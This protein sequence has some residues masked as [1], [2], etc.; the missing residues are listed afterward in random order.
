MTNPFRFSPI[1]YDM[2]CGHL[3]NYFNLQAN[4]YMADSMARANL[5]NVPTLNFGTFTP[6]GGVSIPGEMIFNYTLNQ[7]HYQSLQMGGAGIFNSDGSLN[8]TGNIFGG[9]GFGS[10]IG[11]NYNPFGGIGFTPWQTPSV[12][13]GNGNGSGNGKIDEKLQN[14]YNKLKNLLETYVTKNKNIDEDL[15][16][17]IKEAFKAKGTLEEKY[18]ALKEVFDDIDKNELRKVILTLKDLDN[19]YYED[20][21]VD[22]GYDFDAGTSY[23]HD[24]SELI[25]LIGDARQEIDQLVKDNKKFNTISEKEKIAG[26]A[27]YAKS[28]K[29]EILNIISLWNEKNPKLNIVDAIYKITYLTN[30]ENN[31]QKTTAELI[32]GFNSAL[33]YKAEK[34]KLGLSGEEKEEIDSLIDA[35]STAQTD[36]INNPTNTAKWNTMKTAFNNLYSK[37]RIVEAEKINK[38][39]KNQYGFLNEI[40]EGTIADDIIVAETIADLNDEGIT[41]ETS[42]NSGNGDGAGQGTGAGQGA[43]AGQNT[44]EGTATLATSSTTS[45]ESEAYQA[46]RT[47]GTN[48]CGGRS[49]IKNRAIN[50][51]LVGNNDDKSGIAFSAENVVEFLDGMYSAKNNKKGY[52]EKMDK[53]SGKG[54][55]D[56]AQRKNIISATLEAAKDCGLSQDPSYLTL[57]AVYDEMIKEGSTVKFND[58]NKTEDNYWKIKDKA[59]SFGI[60]VGGG[61]VAG[62][63]AGVATAAGLGMAA[64][65][66]GVVGFLASN[67]V[68]W[69]VAA[70]LAVVAGATAISLAIGKRTNSE[71]IDDCMRDLYEKIKNNEQNKRSSGVAQTEL[72]N[73]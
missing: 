30:A 7:A 57:K 23:E 44:G 45:T 47:V 73:G 18:S 29:D 26:F 69:A 61:V 60:G 43:G 70:C 40:E 33:K 32:D 2:T 71:V 52:F 6:Y 22:T 3:P 35:L 27:G 17:D 9:Y 16:S 34:C 4:M 66:A 54:E 1:N 31:E 42:S 53:R 14:R 11:T 21:L 51:A 58:R 24:N 49:R 38:D 5:Y 41:V 68:G 20:R 62:A 12:D 59:T 50:T 72:G 36:A 39:I 28:S 25:G 56:V 48:L 19:K 10:Q 55:I 15:K 64:G 46:G 65:T 13:N 37:L 63:T 8:L 67:P